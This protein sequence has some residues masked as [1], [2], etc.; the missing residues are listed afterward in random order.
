ME[1]LFQFPPKVLMTSQNLLINPFEI[2][3]KPFEKSVIIK[4][5]QHPSCF[6]DTMHA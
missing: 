2:L 5:I 4:N 3:E 1:Y 6:P